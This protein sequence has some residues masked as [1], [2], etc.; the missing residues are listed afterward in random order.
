MSPILASSYIYKNNKIF[1]DDICSSW[2]VVTFMRPAENFCEHVYM[3]ACTSLFTSITWTQILFPPAHLELY[4]R[5][6]WKIAHV[7]KSKAKQRQRMSQSS[8]TAAT[9]KVEQVSPESSQEGNKEHLPSSSH[10][11]AA[12]LTFSLWNHKILAPDNWDEC[13]SNDFSDPRTSVRILP[14]KSSQFL[15]ISGF[16]LLVV[17]FCFYCLPLVVEMYANSLLTSEQFSQGYLIC[18]L[19][20]RLK[21]SFCPK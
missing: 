12:T 11:T 16:L 3:A 5:A 9:S 13:K 19:P 2:S 17:S 8:V 20:A 10:Q 15:K 4:F 14:Q 7:F 6:I 1:N 21:S 18:L